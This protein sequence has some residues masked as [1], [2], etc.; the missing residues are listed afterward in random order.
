MQ[1]IGSYRVTPFRGVDYSRNNNQVLPLHLVYDNHPITEE[2][3]NM[4][5]HD[6]SQI[7]VN[8]ERMNW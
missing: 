2:N 7:P 8:M 1:R 4:R 5:G 3:R 6:Q